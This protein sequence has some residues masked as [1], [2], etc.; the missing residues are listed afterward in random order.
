M[1]F[2]SKNSVHGQITAAVDKHSTIAA[3]ALTFITSKSQ[4]LGSK[5]TC[6][7]VTPVRYIFC[8]Y[9]HLQQIQ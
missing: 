5:C 6:Y 9:T 1:Y 2:T 8:L 7:L 4:S 3:E